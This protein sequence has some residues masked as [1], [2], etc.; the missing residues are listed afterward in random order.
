MALLQG[1]GWAQWLLL[2]GWHFCF[3]FFPVWPISDFSRTAYLPSPSTRKEEVGFPQCGLYILV[4]LAP[5]G[6]S[7]DLSPSSLISPL[8]VLKPPTGRKCRNPGDPACPTDLAPR[9][10]RPPLPVTGSS[11]LLPGERGVPEP[12]SR[13]VLPGFS[14][15]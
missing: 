2:L 11:L 14:L 12:L 1:R 13:S 7:L 10:H 15:I 5:W 6:L 8:R 4:I 9:H 3:L